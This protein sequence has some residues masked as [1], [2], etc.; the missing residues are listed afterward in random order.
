MFSETPTVKGLRPGCTA[1]VPPRPAKRGRYLTASSFQPLRKCEKQVQQ[2]LSRS[3]APA[4][5]LHALSSTASDQSAPQPALT[6]W[7]LQKLRQAKE[8]GRRNVPVNTLSKEIGLERQLVLNW[9]KHPEQLTTER[10]EVA[11]FVESQPRK[12]RGQSVAAPPQQQQSASMNSSPFQ[13]QER[14]ESNTGL[15]PAGYKNKRLG[16]DIEGTCERVYQQS[17]YPSKQ[18]LRSIHDLHSVPHAR[19]VE[20]FA[21][22]RKQDSGTGFQG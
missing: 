22:R 6:A 9:L 17:R 12:V 7:Q 10:P 8:A 2:A 4:R 20:W 3:C 13:N 18:L 15:W 1:A 19:L 16:R 14:L 21:L 11:G 5:P